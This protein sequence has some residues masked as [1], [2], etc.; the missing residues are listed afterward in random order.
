MVYPIIILPIAAA[1]IAAAIESF[2]LNATHGRVERASKFLTYNVAVILYAVCLSQ[3][4]TTEFQIRN[5]SGPFFV[6]VIYFIVYGSWRGILYSL[7]LN[8]LRYPLKPWWYMSPSSNSIWEKVYAYLFGGLDLP[9]N[10]G[11]FLFIRGCWLLLMLAS[12]ITVK[13]MYY[14]E[15]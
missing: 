15:S 12:T 10:R 11:T 2:Y 5:G 3:V 7:I 6:P 9:I 14:G 8:I 13:L 4:F 1:V